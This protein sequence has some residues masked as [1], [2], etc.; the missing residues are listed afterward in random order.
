MSNSLQPHGLQHERPPCPSPTARVY[1]NLCP[2]SRWWHP[3]ISSSVIPFSC[4]QSFPASGSFPLIQ[5]FASRGQPK[6]WS[7]SFSTSPSNESLELISFRIDRFDPL[8]VQGT[9]KSLFQY[10][11]SKAS[12]PQ[13]SAFFMV[14]LSH[15][16]MTT[17]ETIAWLWCVCFLIHCLGLS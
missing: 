12:I 4:S 9:L 16:S 7:F 1:S 10:H 15:P 3:S 2:S 11:S 17:G 13:H 6:Y 14:P 5:L 8:A